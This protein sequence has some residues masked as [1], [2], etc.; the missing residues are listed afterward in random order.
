MVA[1]TPAIR[2]S[3]TFLMHDTLREVDVGCRGFK[4]AARDWK[5][6]LGSSFVAL[7]SQKLWEAKIT[8]C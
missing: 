4:I 5:L 7:V 1:C 3:R 8:M 6:S 2:D